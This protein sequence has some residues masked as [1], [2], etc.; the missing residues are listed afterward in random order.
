MRRIAPVAAALLLLAPANAYA[1]AELLLNDGTVLVGA[2]VELRDDYYLLSWDGGS[3]VPIPVELVKELRLIEAPDPA[4]TGM[5]VGQPQTLAGPKWA[6]QTPPFRDQIAAFR[7]EPYVFPPPAV[8]TT[9][10]PTSSWGEGTGKT[11]FNPAR[12][13][14][15]PIDPN[16]TPRSAFRASGDV[17][18]FN[19]AR[20]YVPSINPVWE[21]RDAWAPT[22]WFR[23]LIAPRE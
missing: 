10:T 5:R 18:E 11:Q 3:V 9:W 20:W 13:R 19:P 14:T 15:S 12:W 17:T 21:P 22:V 7:R 23:P 2:S 1:G 16:W 6:G 4:P 8:D